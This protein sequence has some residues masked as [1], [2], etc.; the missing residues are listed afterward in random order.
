MTSNGDCLSIDPA[1]KAQLSPYAFI[2]EVHLQHTQHLAST[3]N[4][5]LQEHRKFAM[6]IEIN[7]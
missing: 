6:E 4:A 1:S 2:T 3:G 7:K 5:E